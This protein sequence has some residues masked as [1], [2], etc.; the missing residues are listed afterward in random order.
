MEYPDRLIP[1]SHFKQ[2]GVADLSICFLCRVVHDERFIIQ[3][4]GMYP[5]EMLYKD[6]KELFDYSTNLLGIFLPDDHKIAL[7]GDNKKYFYAYWD[8]EEAVNIPVFE[9]D[10]EI[11]GSRAC[12]FFPI[13][14]L[15]QKT[16]IPLPSPPKDQDE[17]LTPHIVHTPTRSN[18]WHFSIRWKGKDDFETYKGSAWQK[19]ISSTMRA[20]L[21][22]SIILGIPDLSPIPESTYIKT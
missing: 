1:L 18:Y 19:R 15:H 2:I 16:S 12:F 21:Q 22:E 11:D 3:Q 9:Q 17:V 14:A 8:F 5:D 13:S 20:F 6:K 7:I 4:N 10:F